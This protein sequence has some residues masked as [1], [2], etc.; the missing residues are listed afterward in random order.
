MFPDAV[1]ERGRK[2]LQTLIR[3]KRA[4][5]RAVMLYVI[6]RMDVSLFGPARE[7]DPDYAAALDEAVRQGVE[8]FAVQA[9]VSPEGISF[10]RMLPVSL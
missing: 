6:Q 7:I 3:V 10:H 1:T 4:G 9:N 2:H 8:V 5:L